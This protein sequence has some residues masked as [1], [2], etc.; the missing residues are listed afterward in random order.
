[1]P[2]A[3]AGREPEPQ[4]NE[5][6]TNPGDHRQKPPVGGQGEVWNHQGQHG[7]EGEGEA[8]HGDDRPHSEDAIA[9]WARC[10]SHP[11]RVGLALSGG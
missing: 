1:M 6:E 4:Q 8:D 11:T 2:G 5:G 7:D 3:G 10:W 9:G